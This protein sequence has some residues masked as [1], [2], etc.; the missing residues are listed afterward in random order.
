M[1]SY[2]KMPQGVLQ[3]N[4]IQ[5]FSIVGY[6]VLMGLLNFY[7]TDHGGFTKTQANTLTASFFALNFLLH[8]LGGALGGKYFSF[9]GLFLVSVCLQVVSMFMIAEHNQTLIVYS[10]ALF[11][12]GAGLNVSCLNMMLTQLFKTEDHNRRIA[13]SINYSCMNIGFVG[14]FI[15]AGV[16]QSYGAYTIA[17]YTAAGCLALTVILH[18]LNFKNVKDKDT[19]FHN[20]FSKSNARFLVAPGIILVC[21]LFSIFL[22]RHAEFGSNLVICVFILVFI[23]LAFIALKQEPEYRERIIAF[24]LLSSACMI[25]AFVQGM[26]SS[27]LENFVEFNTNKSLFGITMEPATVNTFESLG[28]IIFGFLLAI[29]SKRR[30]KNSTTLPPGSLITRGIGLYIIAFMMIPIGILLANKNTGTV[31]VIFPILLLLIVAA[32]EIHVNATSYALVGDLIKPVHQGIF[33]GYMFVNVAIGIVISGPVSNYA[34][35]KKLKAEDITAL[36]TNQM[37]SNIFVCLT[38]IAIILTIIFF[39]IS[40][41]IN[42]VFDNIK[43]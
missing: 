38:V 40:K 34:I 4:I 8:F 11:I 1:I 6:A 27:A 3:I 36:G 24:M 5:I 19:F 29:L 10:M 13:F 25:F 2:K 14:S 31:N 21:F 33:T 41:K 17:F 42:K 12:T 22:I 23:Y 7:L 35:G 39:L 26:Q 32:G 43:E 20:Q 28:V 15:L 16:I 18:L 37:Y 30:L 9:R